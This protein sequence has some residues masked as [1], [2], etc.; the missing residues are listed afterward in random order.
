LV[1]ASTVAVV[2]LHEKE[3]IRVLHVD[4]EESLLKVARECLHAEG[5]FEVE[6]ALSVE[7]ALK[8]LEEGKFDVVVSDYQMPGKDGLALLKELRDKNNDIPFIMFTGRGREEVAIKALNYGADQYL[9]KSGDPETVYGELAHSIYKAVERKKAKRM[10]IESEERYRSLLESISDSVYLLDRDWR[11][12]IINEGATKLANMHKDKILGKKLP[13]LFPGVE[14]TAFFKTLRKVMETRKPDVVA[15]E[16][17]FPGGRKGWY[18]IHVYPVREGTLCIST[19]ITERKKMENALK[20]SE[21]KYRELVE[22]LHEGI[23]VIDKD[24]CTTFANPRMAEILGY[25]VDEM[26][27]KH[28]FSLMD[29]HGVEICKYYL[30]RRKQGITEQHNFEFIRKDGI[31]IY[32]R[33]GTSPI[34]DDDGNYVGALASVMDLTEQRQAEGN[35]RE[36]E[37]KWRSLVEMAPDGMATIDTKGVFTSVNNAFLRLTG[38]TKEEIVGKHFTKLQTIHAKDLPKYLKLMVAA[39]R[40]KVPKPFE[41]S[42]LRKDGTIGWGEAHIGVLKKNGKTTGYQAIFRE[43]TE[44]KQAEQAVRESQQKFERLFMSNPEAAVYSD[45]KFRIVDANPRFLKLFGYSIDEIKGKQIKDVVVPENKIEETKRL[46][47]SALKGHVYH[48]TVRKRK[49][50]SLV[51]VSASA[52]PLI[53]ENELI[54]YLWIYKDI[55]AMKK[56]EEELAESRRH[57]QTLFNLMVDPV[58][59]VD[60]KGKILELT[61]KV[62]EITG[63]KS[64]EL[65]GKNFLRTKIATRK[66]KAIMIK[67]LTKRMMGMH[68]S[69]YEVEILAKDGRKLVYEINAARIEYKGKPADLVVFR[70]I[71]ERKKMEEKLRVV[72]RL[73]R[74]DVRNKL[75]AITGN[76]YLARKRSADD[77]KFTEY[78]SEI[79]NAVQ[80]TNGIFD[81]ARNYEMLGMEELIYLDVEKTVNEAAQLFNDLKG[82]KITNA[83]RGV[84]VLADHLLRQV[85]YNLIDNSLKYGERTSHIKIYCE[86]KDEHLKLV[87]MDDGMGIPENMKANLFHEAYGKGT[88]YGLYLVRRICE[89]YGWAIQERGKQGTGVQFIITIPKKNQE[90]KALYRL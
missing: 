34:T 46:E 88:G 60:G 1:E 78:L 25:T 59:I 4:D 18:E 58:A 10:L 41:Y 76:V 38:F 89:V 3:C 22:N 43:I 81:F 30:E 56:A 31:R 6:T 63:F 16:Y 21:R 27:G 69:P 72:G 79:E 61:A 84:T 37:E 40:G 42:Y 13:E 71:A 28:L 17:M 86:E 48:D 54:G 33:L 70:D 36:S 83:C 77:P 53:V 2:D 85:F 74:H 68:V 62:E 8:K 82:I 32:A 45:P 39:L 20:N 24:N 12:L 35:L 7:Q 73:T 14:E 49:D 57:F 29:K 50:G 67:N 47:E 55:T 23:W 65:V 11:Y 90:G 5:S 87:C 75:A 9:N 64:E 80:Q 26:Q 66:S 52:A 19:D 15:D 44:R 51:P